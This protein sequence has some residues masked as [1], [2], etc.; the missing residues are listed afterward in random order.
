MEAFY[1]LTLLIVLGVHALALALLTRDFAGGPVLGLCLALAG[2]T[3]LLFTLEH[4]QGLG[5]LRGLAALTTAGSAW[6]I[7]QA[8]GEWPDRRLWLAGLPLLLAFLYGLIWRAN[9]PSIYP[10]SERVTDLY[11]IVNYLGGDTLPPVDHWFPPYAFDFYYALQHYAAALLAR[12][13]DLG[14]GLTYNLAFALITG[15]TLAL[16]WELA[17]RHG[18]RLGHR[19]LL[20]AALAIGGTGASAWT[21][22]V[23]ENTAAKPNN[24]SVYDR[25]AG[26]ARFIGNFDQRI[27]TEVGKTVFAGAID[28]ARARQELPMENFGYQFY[29]GDYHPPLL[30]FLLLALALSLMWLIPST[31]GLRRLALLGGLAAT[32]PLMLAAH[33][34]VFPL[35]ALMVGSWALWQMWFARDDR[36]ALALLAPLVAGGVAMLILLLPFLAGFTQRSLQTGFAWVQPH[37][38]TPVVSFLVLHGPA[39]LLLGLAVWAAPRQR[40]YLWPLALALTAALV[41]SE[42]VYMDDLSGNEYERTNTTMKW[43]GWIWTA[44]LMGVAPAVLASGRAWVRW[45]AVAAL[46][47]TLVYAVDIADYW[48]TTARS[49]RWQLHGEAIYRRDAGGG[50]ILDFLKAAPRGIVVERLSKDAYDD[51][52]TYSALSAQPLFLGWP[53]HEVTWRGQL[54]EIWQRRDALRAIYEGK[55]PN[56]ADYLLAHEVRYIVWS[57]REAPTL[58]GHRQTLSDQLAPH[59]LWRE[60]GRWG[61]HPVGVWVRR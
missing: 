24:V 2:I 32:V 35:H 27:N 12:L 14:P 54:H 23:A 37:Q 53:L 46:A 36:A 57:S 5:G 22:I 31:E 48:K 20:I 18:L 28:P 51:G 8:R 50:A 59:Y 4:A 56:P 17:G 16:A 40:A 38:H 60:L 45:T 21:R 43:W 55:H 6:V 3:V 52:G 44:T 61:E 9:F 26:S 47:S 15:L 34:W 29:I 30:G 10:S 11:F 41:L 7:W 33:T 49:D 13:F 25:M 1:L 39:L 19:L 58:H 42:L